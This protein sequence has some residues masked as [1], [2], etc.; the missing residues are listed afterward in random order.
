MEIARPGTKAGGIAWAAGRSADGR[1][2]PKWAGGERS[3][4]AHANGDRS[5]LRGPQLACETSHCSATLFFGLGFIGLDLSGWA[6]SG[7]IYRAGV[8]RAGFVGL[9]LCRI[10]CDV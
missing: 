4:D 2:S 8:C 3:R 6:L 1:F 9:D 5:D 10:V 7:W